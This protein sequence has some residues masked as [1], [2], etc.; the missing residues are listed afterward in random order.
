MEPQIEQLVKDLRSANEKLEAGDKNQA[1]L[2]EKVEKLEKALEINEVQ[3]Q[4]VTKKFIAAENFAKEQTEKIAGIEKQMYRMP[5]GGGANKTG[6]SEHRK[7]F[8]KFM[9]QGKEKLTAD[10]VKYLRTDNDP[11]GGY[12][13]PYEY[14]EEINK[15]ITE[16]SPIRQ[17]ARVRP[18]TSPGATTLTRD[19]LVTA[20]WTG[21]GDTWTESHSEY[22]QGEIPLHSITGKVKITTKS[23]FGSRFNM[24]SEIDTDLR[25]S[26]AQV[27]GAGFVSGNAVKK[28]QGFM[29][30]AT[31]VAAAATSGIANDMTADNLIDLAGSLKTGYNPVYLLNRTT[32]AAIRKMKDGSG[33]YIWQAGN[34]AAGVPNALNGYSYVEV[35][36]MDDIGTNKYPVA[37]GDFRKGYLIVDGLTMQMLRNPYKDDGFVYFTAERFVGGQVV[38]P[39]AIKILKC[40]V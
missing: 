20:Y 10:E 13:A 2:K 12:L 8:E 28:P 6:K 11:D 25:E 23:L 36:D 32:I 26:F 22:G 18:I 17:I 33:A 15:K 40:A 38:L 35:P 30:N 16:V 29:V 5:N 9:I 14:L 27:E 39:E 7:A 24:E 3:N 21:E 31:V 4:E 37:F 1:E 34:L 19:T